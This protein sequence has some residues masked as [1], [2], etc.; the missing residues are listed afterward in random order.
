MVYSMLHAH[1]LPAFVMSLS[2][3]IFEHLPMIPT[4]DVFVSRKRMLTEKVGEAAPFFSLNCMVVPVYGAAHCRK[5]FRFGVSGR[6]RATCCWLLFVTSSTCCHCTRPSHRSCCWTWWRV[7][8]CTCRLCEVFRAAKQL[9]CD[10]ASAIAGRI[11]RQSCGCLNL[12]CFSE[13]SRDAQASARHEQPAFAHE[14]SR[15][16]LDQGAQVARTLRQV[17]GIQTEQSR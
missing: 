8:S 3:C 9:R 4:E 14:V 10:H 16:A 7:P 2:N 6:R 12:A 15:V 13:S 17:N 1:D 11:T 5:T